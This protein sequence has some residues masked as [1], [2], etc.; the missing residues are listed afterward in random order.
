MDY[1]LPR[2]L[3]STPYPQVGRGTGRI[4]VNVGSGVEASFLR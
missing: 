1:N 2:S 3:L 4:L